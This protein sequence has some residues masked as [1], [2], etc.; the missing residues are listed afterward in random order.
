MIVWKMIAFLTSYGDKWNIE[1]D[2]N[3]KTKTN[4]QTKNDDDDDATKN[5]V[6][7]DHTTGLPATSILLSLSLSLSMFLSYHS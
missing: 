2:D 1:N 4:K 6:V 7:I 5:S 3:E